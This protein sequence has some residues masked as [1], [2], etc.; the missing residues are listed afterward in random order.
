MAQGLGVGRIQVEGAAVTVCRAGQIRAGF[1]E[2]AEQAPGV[3]R[4]GCVAQR[5][6]G[7]ASLLNRGPLPHARTRAHR[8]DTP[9]AEDGRWRLCRGLRRV[10]HDFEE[11]V[12]RPQEQGY[13]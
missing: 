3:G 8:A 13:A 2:H 9:L 4:R 1:A 10:L 11:L 5:A 7:G 12:R 6:P